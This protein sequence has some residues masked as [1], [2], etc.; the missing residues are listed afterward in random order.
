MED[1]LITV[2]VQESDIKKMKF[3]ILFHSFRQVNL[4]D[5]IMFNFPEY[6]TIE[7]KNN[8]LTGRFEKQPSKF[9]FQKLPFDL[10][11][12]PTQEERIKKQGANVI[13]TGRYKEKQ[14]TFFTGLVPKDANTFEGD[15]MEFYKGLKKKSLIIFVFAPDHS[16]MTVYFFNHY[17]K[18]NRN[19]R[20]KFCQQFIGYINKNRS[21]K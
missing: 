12:E 5:K 1:F 19:E 13:I 2:S 3:S 16:T 4:K 7:F 17:Y 20:L 11:I 8:P 15:H 18:E 6:K 14:R 21:Q 9:S 10:K